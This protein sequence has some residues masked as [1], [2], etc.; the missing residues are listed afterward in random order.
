MGITTPFI[1]KFS[2]A[3]KTDEDLVGKKAYELGELLE[4]G[5]SIPDGFVIT[6]EFYKE[7]VHS[8]GIDKEIA[9]TQ[10]D[11]KLLASI[12]EKI[13]HEDIPS[14]LVRELL[15]SYK[16]LSG[17]FR[18]RPLNIFS[19]NTENKM[20]I[21]SNIS[22]DANF[23]LKIKKIWASSP[24][25]PLA[26]IVQEAIPSG[27]KGKVISK[28]PF[29]LDKKITK[30]QEEELINYCNSIRKHY[31]FPQEIEYVISK[32]KIIVTKISPFAPIVNK[33]PK[34]AL[35]ATRKVLAKG[36]PVNPG[37][38]VG[39]IK[40][41]H[42]IHHKKTIGKG[43]IVI[44]SSFDRSIFNELRKAKA[45]IL[46]FI[47][48]N[49]LNKTIFRKTCHIPAIEG[50][51]NATKIFQNKKIITVNGGNGEIYSGGLIY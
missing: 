49:T 36:I 35:S 29:V 28:E 46:D 50:I 13:I 51:K 15:K 37:I 33:S 9:K 31:Y 23:I 47:Q 3:N 32:D 2:E 7:F 34:R 12:S 25:K 24:A 16:K 30:K 6:T 19:L 4:M 18:E 17:T 40:I 27:I 14:K 41:V 44:L 48:P 1:I 20:I 26:I 43:D 22:G 11:E 38:A 21:Y 8:T 10:S 42:D 45:V 39:P 5:V